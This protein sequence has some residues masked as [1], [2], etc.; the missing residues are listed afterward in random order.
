MYSDTIF[1]NNVSLE[2]ALCGP[3][4]QLVLDLP[5]KMLAANCWAEGRRQVFQVSTEVRRHRERKGD[6][7]M[8]W[9]WGRE[10]VTAI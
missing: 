5:I 6:F 1:E 7:A 8:L 10:N 9:G 3:V 4:T 2:K